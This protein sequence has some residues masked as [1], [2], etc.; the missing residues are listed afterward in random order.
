MR[1]F[2]G[3]FLSFLLVGF[4]SFVEASSPS[5]V[6]IADVGGIGDGGINDACWLGVQRAAKEFNLKAKVVQMLNR[7]DCLLSFYQNT[8]ENDL[9]L[10][11]GF[12]MEEVFLKA[13]SLYPDRRFILIDGRVE[14]NNILSVLFKD[15]EVGFLA[16]LLASAVTKTGR[17]AYVGG[18]G[19]VKSDRYL[20]GYK[21]GVK[22]YST[23]SKKDVKVVETYV[24]TFNSPEKGKGTALS[25]FDQGID[26][27]FQVAGQ[28]GLGVLEAAK[29]KGKGFF[30][31]GVDLDK[32]LLSG[33]NLLANIVRRID[34]V[35]YLAI[36]SLVKEEAM[37]RVLHVGL[38]E[39]VIEAEGAF[40]G[41]LSQ[42]EIE[43]IDKV[44]RMVIDGKLV[45]PSSME[46]FAS[47]I[48][49]DT[50]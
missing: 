7:E 34:L 20:I 42:R 5:L 33:D 17:V 13:S 48:P 30:V 43:L 10:G 15:E 39:G 21:A 37:Q 26:V 27:I 25:L 40:E 8:Q 35:A 19:E 31:I 18:I 49:P 45:V 12:L 46:E 44:K 28:S 22:V 14:A 50:I 16:G 47:F 29:E 36:I 24:G 11:V 9:V 32:S 23:L 4:T 6:F 3:F 1:Y 2:L 38:R 41:R